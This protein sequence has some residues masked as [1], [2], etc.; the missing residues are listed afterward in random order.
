MLTTALTHSSYANQY[1][2]ESYERLEF[3]GDA[4]LGFVAADEL[5]S[6]KPGIAEGKMSARRSEM[7]REETLKEAAVKLS[8][9][10]MMRIGRGEDKNG[11]RSNPSILADMVEAV[12]AAIYLD[13][14]FEN[15]KK[16]IY[17]HVFSEK[18]SAR[19]YKGIL[20]EKIQEEGTCEIRYVLEGES[21]PD[22]DKTF[23]S[24]VYVNGVK[25]GSGSGKTK[26]QAEQSAAGDAYL[27]WQGKK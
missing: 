13:S 2:V 18:S 10:K 25:M 26:Q 24:S 6:Q 15:A 1:G 12:I 7:V 9:P 20:Q 19:N 14:G 8:I 5:Y 17:E 11:G 16:F 23:T 27:K 4:I 21:G 22:H 3:L